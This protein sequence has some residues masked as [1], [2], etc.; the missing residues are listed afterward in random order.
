MRRANVT[1]SKA[2]PPQNVLHLFSLQVFVSLPYPLP[3]AAKVQSGGKAIYGKGTFHTASIWTFLSITYK[4][5]KLARRFKVN[6]SVTYAHLIHII[7][8][9]LQALQILAKL[10]IQMSKIFSFS[11][12]KQIIPSQWSQ[13]TNF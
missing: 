2:H 6:T 5:Y 8:I 9:N 13:T 11:N 12:T 1:L 7:T 10:S 4:S 3:W